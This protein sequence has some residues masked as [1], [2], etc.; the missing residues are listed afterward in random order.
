[1][2]C[3]L[4][5]SGLCDFIWLFGLFG[6]IL[7]SR[8]VAP[9]T[10]LGSRWVAP[11]LQH[12]LH[13]TYLLIELASST[14]PRRVAPPNAIGLSLGRPPTATLEYS[15]FAQHTHIVHTCRAVYVYLGAEVVLVIRVIT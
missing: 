10:R 11:L 7:Q 15:H 5:L 13:N 4:V 9:Q 14:N 8:R 1:M 3:R 2:R 12:S 6:V